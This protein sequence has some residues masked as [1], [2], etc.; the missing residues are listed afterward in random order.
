MDGKVYFKECCKKQGLN[1]DKLFQLGQSRAVA[2]DRLKYNR[3]YLTRKDTHLFVVCYFVN[4]GV[5]VA[6]NLKEPKG[7]KKTAFNINR[8]AVEIPF[9]GAVHSVTKS[10]EYSGWDEETV[11]VFAPNAVEV[12]LRNYCRTE[13]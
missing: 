13:I 4:E 11:F 8:S 7:A 2:A 5:Y 10:I 3:S 1:C 6:W 9:D 12:F